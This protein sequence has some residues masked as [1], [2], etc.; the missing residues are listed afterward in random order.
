MN[1]NSKNSNFYFPPPLPP[2][3]WKSLVYNC[4]WKHTGRILLMSPLEFG[5]GEEGEKE[6]NGWKFPRW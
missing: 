5:G 1:K 6:L 4:T 3:P 2:P